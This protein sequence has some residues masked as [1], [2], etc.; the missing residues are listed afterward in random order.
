MG[1][2]PEWKVGY[3][4]QGMGHG[5]HVILA[6]WHTDEVPAALAMPDRETAE[7][8]VSALNPGDKE[9]PLYRQGVLRGWADAR[10]RGAVILADA[11]RLLAK[12]A[13]DA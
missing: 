1:H 12:A 3:H 11:A 2:T 6:P 8:A 13:P 9:H 10:K 7:R 5:Y 4:D